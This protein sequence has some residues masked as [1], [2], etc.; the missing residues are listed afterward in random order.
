MLDCLRI[1]RLLRNQELNTGNTEG[2]PLSRSTILKDFGDRGDNMSHVVDRMEVDGLVE[3]VGS[4]CF[5]ITSH[6]REVLE[7]G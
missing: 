7:N 1:L 3:H 4:N 6:G 5:R 2:I